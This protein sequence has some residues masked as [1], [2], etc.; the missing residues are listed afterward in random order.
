MSAPT[1]YPD[2]QRQV[3]WDGPVLFN[4]A[5]QPS[6]GA[7]TT[8]PWDVSRFA[9]LDIQ[10]LIQGN[11]GLMTV[12]WYADALATVFLS[13][14]LIPL[15]NVTRIPK[16]HFRLINGGPY[17]KVTFSNVVGAYNITAIGF[18]SNRVH[19]LQGIP[20]DYTLIRQSAVAINAGQ[21]LEFTPLS[22]YAGPAR[23]S[24][25]TAGQ[26]MQ[27]I[28]NG[29]NTVCVYEPIDTFQMTGTPQAANTILPLGA[30]TVSVDNTS[31]ANSTVW[32]HVVGSASGSS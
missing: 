5:A 23:I 31:A 13:D 8:G 6:G 22:L 28:V 7:F 18:G 20:R 29:M 1:G 16:F 26:L 4:L 19:P 11:A 24:I 32:I 12:Q 2:W 17:V 14:V 30:W 15:D 3:S 21:T 25:F 9:Y 27:P 10:G